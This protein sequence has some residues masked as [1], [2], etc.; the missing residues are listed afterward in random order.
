MSLWQ[1]P[2]EVS[3]RGLA[4]QALDSSDPGD[5]SRALHTVMEIIDSAW[6]ERYLWL[7]NA[8]EYRVEADEFAADVDD[9]Q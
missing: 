5:M 9:V 3:I 2:L 4:A 1:N 6:E 7:D 8:T